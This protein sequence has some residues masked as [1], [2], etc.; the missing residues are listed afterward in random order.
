[1]IKNERDTAKT[2]IVF[3]AASKIG[4]NPS[5]NDCLHS[6]PCLLPLI[7]DILLRFRIGDVAL[8]ADIK[9]AFLNI[10]IDEEERDFFRFLWVENISEKDK[11]VVYRFL[12]VAFGVTSSPL[13]LAAKIKSHVTKY[14]IAQ[15]ALVA[16]KKL[17]RDMYVDDVATSFR[18]ME[19]GLE[20]YF[21]S[22]KMFERRSF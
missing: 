20:S 17:L 5:L 6:G 14:I 7:F 8:V 16:L 9:Q 13:I 2:R 12:R 19:E 15:I 22:K 18:T 10:E 3:D 1:M 4:N 11:I 21:E